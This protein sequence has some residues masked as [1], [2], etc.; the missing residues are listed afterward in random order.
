MSDKLKNIEENL[1]KAFKEI[2]GNN[3]A[4]WLI[5]NYAVGPCLVLV[6]LETGE[7]KVFGVG[8]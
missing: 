6:D 3:K 7:E 1:T 2:L 4:A 5:R 8:D